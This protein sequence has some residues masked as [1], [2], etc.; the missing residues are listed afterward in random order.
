MGSRE[1]GKVK[2]EL[3]A[4]ENNATMKETAKSVYRGLRK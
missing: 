4:E 2:Y 1:A 3:E